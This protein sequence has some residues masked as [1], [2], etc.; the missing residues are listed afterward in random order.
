MIL[1]ATDQLCFNFSLLDLHL[2]GWDAPKTVNYMYF[3]LTIADITVLTT[4]FAALICSYVTEGVFYFER[5]T[6]K[7][8]N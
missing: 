3:Y 6:S 8:K 4:T 1:S 7:V 5:L 2:S